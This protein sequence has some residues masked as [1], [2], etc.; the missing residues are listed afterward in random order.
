MNYSLETF[1]EASVGGWAVEKGGVVVVVQVK[2]AVT[3]PKE[4]PPPPLIPPLLFTSLF[5]IPTF[6]SRRPLLLF[7]RLYF[8]HLPFF[9]PAPILIAD[10]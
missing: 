3:L 5:L 10:A 6:S 9:Q 7:P 2:A 4:H 1:N 8:F